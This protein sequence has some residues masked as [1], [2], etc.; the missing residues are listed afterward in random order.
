MAVSR[1]AL[2]VVPT[3]EERENIASTIDAVLRASDAD[4][5]VVDDASPDGTADVV[6]ALAGE[7]VHLLER[8]GERGLGTAYVAGFRWGLERGYEILVEMDADG[9]HPVDRL[10]ALI[11]QV[12]SGRA[13]LA[14][15]SRWVAGGA[16][17]DWPWRR[18]FL[19]RAANLY[20]RLA[21]GLRVRDV[22]AGYRAFSAE[23]LRRFDLAAVTARGYCFQID[24]TVRARDVGGR[25][26]ELPIEFRDRQKGVSKMNAGIIVEAVQRVT[27]WGLRRLAGRP[28]QER[29]LP[30][31]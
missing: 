5:L 2:V 16:V 24:M 13:D 18:E 26:V 6:R 8:F 1:G 22:T 30:E 7:R 4:I 9:S 10:P 28:L 27:W 25:I 19:S 29:P 15:G 17:A 12:R 23:L 3:Y 31:R 11:D 21:L 20:A 14:I